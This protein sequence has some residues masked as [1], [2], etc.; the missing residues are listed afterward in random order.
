MDDS[1][2]FTKPKAE[3]DTLL[4]T[5]NVFSQEA[6][7]QFSLEKCAT[8]MIKDSKSVEVNYS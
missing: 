5:S 1:E 4:N 7:I 8:L 2:L 3:L 6:E